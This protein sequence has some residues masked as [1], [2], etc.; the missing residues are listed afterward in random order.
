MR[1]KTGARPNSRLTHYAS[2]IT[3]H[4]P[5]P[6][7][8]VD[9][10]VY[11]VLQGI[12]FNATATNMKRP[13]QNPVP[14]AAARVVPVGFRGAANLAVTLRVV[15]QS[16]QFT[17]L[18]PFASHQFCQFVSSPQANEAGHEF[19]MHYFAGKPETAL[20]DSLPSDWKHDSA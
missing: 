1:E 9:S 3:P 19:S 11:Y 7:K 5:L 17:W 16:A 8:S 12:W 4:L 6:K 10:R 20:F 18:N 15:R 2:R 13:W 14:L